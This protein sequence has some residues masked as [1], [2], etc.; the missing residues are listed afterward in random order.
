MDAYVDAC[1]EDRREHENITEREAAFIRIQIQMG[2]A[3]YC[4]IDPRQHRIRLQRD[5]AAV[6]GSAVGGSAMGASC[7]F[8][9]NSSAFVP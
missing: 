9:G 4:R 1:V 5:Q 7:F 2:A 3:Q 6:G 8:F